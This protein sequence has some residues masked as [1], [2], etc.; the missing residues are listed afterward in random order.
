MKTKI[1]ELCRAAGIATAYQL[2][3]KTDLSPSQ[4]ARLYKDEVEAMSLSVLEKLCNTLKCSPDDIFG[5]N[6]PQTVKP[7]IPKP[8]A[9]K[10]AEQPQPLET[11]ASGK[12]IT[13]EQVAQRLKPIAGKI[14][15]KK[16][17]TEYIN[18]GKL[19]STQHGKRS[20]HLVSEVDYLEFEAWYR[21]SK[22]L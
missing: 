10:P 13:T 11:T 14:L 19:K 5:Y 6:E 21:E 16:R 12:G 2:Q 4:A 1:N 17:I 18:E 22:N 3:K 9:E 20:P 7:Q 15:S 8:D